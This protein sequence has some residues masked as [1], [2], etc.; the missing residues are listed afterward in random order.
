MND[1]LANFQAWEGQPLAEDDVKDEPGFYGLS[2]APRLRLHYAG[3]HVTSTA[4]KDR[5]GD[6]HPAVWLRFIVKVIGTERYHVV[7][8]MMDASIALELA[9]YLAQA[10]ERAPLDIAAGFKR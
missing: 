6:L 7:E 9:L 3:S 4:R 2:R 10:A 8:G 1:P 5:N